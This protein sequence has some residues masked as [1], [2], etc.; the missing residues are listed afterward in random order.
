MYLLEKQ[1]RSLI[2]PIAVLSTVLLSLT[3]V[4]VFSSPANAA[5][6]F[7]VFY[8]GNTIGTAVP[9]SETQTRETPFA[10]PVAASVTGSRTGYTFG[11][12]SLAAGG[13]AVASPYTYSADANRL[14]LFAVWNTTISYNLN[15][16]DSGSLTGGKTSDVYRFGQNLTL[17]TVGTLA[18]SGYAFGGWMAA[19]VSTTRITS[20]TAGSTELGNPTLY[21]AWIK[22]VSFNANTATIG[23]V[24]SSLTFVAG[25][26]RLKLPV[27]SEM[28]LRK[29]GYDFVGWS[30]SATGAVVTTP[31]SYIPVT[32]TQTLYAIWKV[33]SD[34]ATSR[35]FF[36]SGKSNLR[37]F[38]KL[39]L[40]DL[41]QAME[42]KQQIKITVVATRARGTLKAL[43]KNRN[44]AVVRYLRS[45]GVEAAFTRKNT[46]GTGR[47]AADKK[48]NRVTIR[49]S[50]TNGS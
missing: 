48:N 9:A 36:K 16:A 8:N 46:L 25:G 43:G 31:D 45:L 42:G 15:G 5:T 34:K 21:A 24:P 47:L 27:A 6:P 41:V 11:G 2:K 50:W 4:V 44:T 19:S 13:Q 32:A 39:V 22:T 18:K 40:N 23:T 7:D 35:V 10:L 20:Y 37:A 28:T 26:T 14:D 29:T 30:T 1:L 3:G 33:Q 38:E 17:P 49:A 12:W